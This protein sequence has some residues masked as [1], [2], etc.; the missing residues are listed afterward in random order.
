[1]SPAGRQPSRVGVWRKTF[2]PSGIVEIDFLDDV[3][4]NPIPNDIDAAY[5][6]IHSGGEAQDR[7]VE[8]V[9][10]P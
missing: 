5:Y 3:D 8:W 6:L 10:R 1:M 4:E 7:T 2:E 9:L